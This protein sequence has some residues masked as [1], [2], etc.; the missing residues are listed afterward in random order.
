MSGCAAPGAIIWGGDYLGARLPVRAACSP[1]I[2]CDGAAGASDFVDGG[3]TDCHRP[4]LGGVS[5]IRGRSVK[6]VSESPQI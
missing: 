2:R 1:F 4:G 5:L 6:F 3:A